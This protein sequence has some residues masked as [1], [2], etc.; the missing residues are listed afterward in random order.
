MAAKYI[1]MDYPRI[2]Q[3]P[4]L[5][6][7]RDIHD[8]LTRDRVFWEEKYRLAQLPRM[9][10]AYC[11]Y[12]AALE[13]KA[14]GYSSFSVIE[15]GVAGGNGLVNC[16][17]H[18]KEIARILSMDIEVYGFDS[19]Q[20]LPQSC[21]GYKDMIHIWPAGSFHMDREK[22]QRR[23]EFAKLVIGDL[24][25]TLDDFLEKYSPAPIGCMLVDVDYYSSTLPILNFLEQR[26]KYFLPR[27]HMY[28]DDIWPEYEFQGENLA[29]K[30][31]N[32]RNDMIK[33][34]P[35]RMYHTDHRAR[36]KICHR[37][38][39]EKYNIPTLVLDGR[40]WN[41]GDLELPL[42]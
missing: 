8:I 23:L 2:N 9:H 38:T 24:E 30:E 21:V 26:D 39:H 16:E 18:S 37:F 25:D 34:S 35:E 33:I 17:F 29:I 4:V 6:E 19:S 12:S 13:A 42:L 3:I 41:S 10:Y 14:L 32:N 28:F 27:V 5:N 20:G 7:D 40:K 31:F 1:F 36:T 11:I 15:F 22:L